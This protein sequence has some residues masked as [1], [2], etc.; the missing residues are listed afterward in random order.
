MQLEQ[1]G[2]ITHILDEVIYKGG[3]GDFYKREFIIKT[4]D[5]EYPQDLKFEVHGE[6]QSENVSKYN[7]VGDVVNVMF[8]IRG[9]LFTNSKGAE[10]SFPSLVAWRLEKEA[11]SESNE[12]PA[13]EEEDDL[14]F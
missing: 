6:K 12:A 7:N 5:A 11:P 9:K 3:K 2:T 13:K 4:D 10:T 14:P 8:N 1:R